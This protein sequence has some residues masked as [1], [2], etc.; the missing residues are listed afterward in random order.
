MRGLKKEELC[1]LGL[2]FVCLYVNS[3]LDKPS[4][5]K[6]R[7]FMYIYKV[8]NKQYYTTI[9]LAQPSKYAL[10]LQHWSLRNPYTLVFR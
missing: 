1:V 6:L 2:D 10:S 3:G 7:M 4:E 5:S 9:S 8:P